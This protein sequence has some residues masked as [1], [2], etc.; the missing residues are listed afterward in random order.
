VSRALEVGLI[1]F[2]FDISD[3]T[4]RRRAVGPPGGV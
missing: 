2:I 1:P 4:R 3:G